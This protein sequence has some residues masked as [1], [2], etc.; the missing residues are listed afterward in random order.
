MFDK[1]KI[2]IEVVAHHVRC[3]SETRERAQ[4]VGVARCRNLLCAGHVGNV[5][6]NHFE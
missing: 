3:R 5:N 1:S 4:R 2:A 6:V